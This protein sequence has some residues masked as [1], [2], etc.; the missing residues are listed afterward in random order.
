MLLIGADGRTWTDK[1]FTSQDFKSCA[2][3]NFATSANNGVKSEIWTHDT[4][5]G[6][7]SLAG[8]WYKPLTHTDIRQSFFTFQAVNTDCQY[9]CF[10]L[11]RKEFYLFG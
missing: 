8:K 9:L 11:Q 1:S 3:A 2:F 6:Y 7:A 4:L 5:L 10:A